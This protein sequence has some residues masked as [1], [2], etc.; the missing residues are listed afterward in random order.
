[1]AAISYFLRLLRS[2]QIHRFFLQ[3]VQSS[4]ASVAF[5]RITNGENRVSTEER[6]NFHSHV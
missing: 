1:M 2:L 6:T 5:I 3:H 4:G